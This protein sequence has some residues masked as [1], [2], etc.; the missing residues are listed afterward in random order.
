[1]TLKQLEAFYWAATCKNFSVAASRLN[2]SV[3]SL[4]KRIG[5]LESAIGAAL[6]N[7]DNRSA[8]L[9]PLG[10][11]LLTHARDVLRSAE[12]FMRR[13]NDA[14][15]LSGRCRFGVGELTSLTWMPRLIA[16][17]QRSHPNLAVEPHSN[18]GQVLETQ[19]EDGELDF[20][21]IAG[22]STRTAI[23]SHGIGQVQFVWVAAPSLYPDDPPL[24]AQDVAE[25]T[26]I[27]L[28]NSAGTVRIL[29][30][31]L[32]EHHVATGRRM[33]CENLGAVA[34]ML[35]EGLGIGFL[36]RAWAAALVQRGHLIELA[37]FPPLRPLAYTYQWRRDDTRPMVQQ[38]RDLATQA[39][40]FDILPCLM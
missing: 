36:P 18:L 30:E 15:A 38:L 19:L 9:T 27:T 24:H 35:K 14:R 23:A 6:F 3:S 8:V 34:G 33:T 21:I 31:W 37:W 12:H 4:S 32:A 16:L 7:R 11:R 28:P 5:E 10:D 39:V 17:I 26:L 29:D 22:P 2:I 13:A 1:M 25:Q 40:D 20:A